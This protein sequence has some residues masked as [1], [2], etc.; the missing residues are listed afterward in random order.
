VCVY[1][2][3]KPGSKMESITTAGRSILS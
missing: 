1:T 2:D 3:V